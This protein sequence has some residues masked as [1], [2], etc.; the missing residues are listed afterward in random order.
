MAFINLYLFLVDTTVLSLG[1]AADK[2]DAEVGQAVAEKLQQLALVRVE[3]LALFAHLITVLG[4]HDVATT[5]GRGQTG[6]AELGLGRGR[7]QLLG[8]LVTEGTLIGSDDDGLGGLAASTGKVKLAEILHVLL[9]LLSR[10]V[11]EHQANIARKLAGELVETVKE[12]LVGILAQGLGH[13]L[14][15]ANKESTGNEYKE[16]SKLFTGCH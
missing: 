11:C 4:E 14:V 2:V 16:F 6:G 5:Q 9:N 1:V 8:H 15:T 3:R 7:D 13:H 12:L 10:L